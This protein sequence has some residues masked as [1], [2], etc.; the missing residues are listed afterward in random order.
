VNGIFA[1]EESKSKNDFEF[2]FLRQRP[3]FVE[4]RKEKLG[5]LKLILQ[6]NNQMM[7][8]KQNFGSKP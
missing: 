2:L 5:A 4:V 1:E 6:R 7:F 8:M 3:G